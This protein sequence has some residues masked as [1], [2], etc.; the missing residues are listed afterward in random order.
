MDPDAA[1]KGRSLRTGKNIDLR[2]R[3]IFL[4]LGGSIFLF[5]GLFNLN[6]N[7]TWFL[8]EALAIVDVFVYQEQKSDKRQASLKSKVFRLLGWSALFLV[9]AVAIL[10]AGAWF[11]RIS[12][13]SFPYLAAIA[14]GILGLGFIVW[15]YMKV[16][17]E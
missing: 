9:A 11:W 8:L 17:T 16:S 15:S 6:G 14:F 4:I 7:I 13:I 1:Q 10:V 5:Q 12:G 3:G 2:R